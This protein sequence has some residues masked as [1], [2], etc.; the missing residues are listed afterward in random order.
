MFVENKGFNWVRLVLFFRVPSFDSLRLR[1]GFASFAEKS[2]VDSSIS[3]RPGAPL[4]AGSYVTDKKA[5]LE[6][7]VE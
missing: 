1:N 5:L 3:A 4:A 6:S 2:W 7:N